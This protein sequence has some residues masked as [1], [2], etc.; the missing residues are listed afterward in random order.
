[1]CQI[2]LLHRVIYGAIV[3]AFVFELE[4]ASHSTLS[5]PGAYSEGAN[6][7]WVIIVGCHGNNEEHL[8][9]H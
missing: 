8:I 2:N 4:L 7:Q 1:M 9:Q 6:F 5:L 3:G